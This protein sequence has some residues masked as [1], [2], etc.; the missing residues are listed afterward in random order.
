M[1]KMLRFLV[2]FLLIGLL[3]ILGGMLA[4]T[5]YYSSNFPVNTWINGVYCTGKS[6]EQVNEELVSAQEASAIVIVD[7][8]GANWEIDMQ[9]AD[10]RP[11]F[12]DGLK[13]YLRQNASV[14]W[15][16]NLQKPV[17]SQLQA[18]VYTADRE[19]LQASLEEL[20]FVVEE[21]DKAPGVRVCRGEEGY[22]LQDGNV[23]RLNLEKA[24]D[25]LEECL[26]KGQTV[27]NLSEG[28]CYEDIPDSDSDRLQR[29]IW[30]QV[31]SFTD[32]GSRII[33]DMGAEQ[34]AMTP[35]VLAGFLEAEPDGS[36]SL[37]PEGNLKISEPSVRGWIEELAAAYDTCD[38]EREFASTRGDTV[39]VKY[40]TY[41]TKLDVETEGTYLL[42]ALRSDTGGEGLHVPAYVQQGYVRGLDDI[43]G[44]YIEIDMT[45]Q[46]MYYYV[47][48]ELTLETDIVTGNTGRRMGTPQGINFV[49]AKQRNRT[50][51]GADYAS[52]VKYWVPVKGN[53]GIH[54]A[55]WRSKFGGQIYKS[56]GSHGCINTPSNIMSQLYEMVEIGTPVIMFY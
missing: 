20:P 19:K 9:A 37:D 33:Y 35:D 26:G 45:D 43:G 7:V 32:R 56:N 8:H 4:L 22:Y 2:V 11:D 25:Y 41:G 54:D 42:E 15:L 46:K 40:V 10:I 29:D 49:Y 36:L 17:S 14:H 30:T 38:K 13:A 48:G 52:F 21:R 1:K 12:T 6:V 5:W 34:I 31:C 39:T 44:T 51:R 55:S 27:I 18:E 24:S 3:L 28:G 16:S 23:H 47:A 53:I 50:L